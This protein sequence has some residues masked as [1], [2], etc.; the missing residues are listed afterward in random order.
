MK[1]IMLNIFIVLSFMAQDV[2]AQV[3]NT[4]GV[5]RDA[6]N[7]AV[8]DGDYQIMFTIYDSEIGGNS[9]WSDTYTITVVNGV[10][11]A[12]LD[13]GSNLD[14]AGTIWLSLQVGSDQ[15]MSR[16]QL[17]Y[18]PYDQLVIS[19]QTNIFP[20]AGPVGIGTTD[21]DQSSMLDV[22][23]RI[24]DETGY[25]APVGTINMFAGATAPEGWLLCDGSELPSGSDYDMLD[26]VLNGA[27]GQG[28]RSY[29]PD[30]RGKVGVGFNSNQSAFS[31]MGN[32][33][34]QT[35]PTHAQ[36][37]HSGST[38]SAGNHYHTM[39]S[40]SAGGGNPGTVRRVGYDGEQATTTDGAH[41]HTIPASSVGDQEYGNMPP[42]IIINYIIK[43]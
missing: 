28:S 31:I 6:N 14:D 3:I 42:Y 4:Q 16:V 27:Y 29:I 38:E 1:K 40:G 15:E 32:T 19:G 34:G 10:Y 22:V 9:L 43:Y 25:V 36:H 12:T 18:S 26:I 30:L 41:E 33:G 20:E 24:K 39:P 37:D 35:A 21:P 11:S 23:G 5:L 8:S 13:V 2:V 17:H 7:K